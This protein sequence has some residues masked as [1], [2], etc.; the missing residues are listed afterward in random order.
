MRCTTCDTPLPEGALFC[1]TCG[2]R[3]AGAG[4]DAPAAR[5]T[6]VEQRLPPL[7][8]PPAEERAIAPALA[9]AP[10]TPTS[11][12]AIVSLV[13]GILGVVFMLPLIGPIVAVVA[14]HVARNEI[15]RADGR[16][17][18]DGMALAG[19][20]MGYTMLVLTLLVACIGVVIILFAI[21]AAAV[22]EL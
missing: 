19:L 15:R 11:T 9:A 14:G 13:F 17:A 7:R 10:D 16:L 1:P 12:A 20:V 6:A 18:G 2:T 5:P 3:T 21:G 22:S 4:A 8:L